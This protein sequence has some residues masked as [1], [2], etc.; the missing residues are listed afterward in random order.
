MNERARPKVAVIGAGMGG[1]CAA[2][3]LARQGDLDV[4]V[5]EAAE[6]PGGVLHTSQAEGFVREHA[7]NGF[8]PVRD[9]EG[10]LDL[11]RELGVEVA[12]AAP[13]ARKRWIYRHGKLCALPASPREFVTTDLLSF[14]G[15]LAALAEPFR[16]RGKQGDESVLAF[17]ERRLGKEVAEAIVAPFVTGVFAGNAEE[18]SIEA[19]FPAL[20]ALEE[21]GGLVVGQV[22]N[23]LGRRQEARKAGAA[24][25]KPR[26]RGGLRLAA[27]VGGV[28]ALVDALARDLG[29]ALV[30]GKTL[31]GLGPGPTLMFADGTEHKVDAVVLAT[32]AH[33][34]A[35]LLAGS[36][37]ELADALA[38]FPY[39]PVAIVYLGARRA[40]ITHPLDGFGFL[41][42]RGEDLRMLG[43]V[44]ESVLW[45]ERAPAGLVLLRCMFGGARDPG[46]MDLEDRALVEI[47][48]RDLDRAL[49]DFARVEP[50]HTHVVRWPQAIAQYTLGHGERVARAET[51]ARPLGIT[52]A[53]SAYHGVAVN[54]L[55]SDARRVVAAVLAQVGR[56]A[57][58]LLAVLLVACAG[59]RTGAGDSEASGRVQENLS[60]ATNPEQGARERDQPMT[61]TAPGEDRT[62]EVAVTVTWPH[63]PA[64]LRRPEGRNPCGAWRHAP[65]SVDT[66]GGVHQAVV[67]LRGAG[68]AAQALSRDPDARTREPGAGEAPGP[69]DAEDPGDAESAKDAEDANDAEDASDAEAAKGAEDAKDTDEAGATPAEIAVRACRLEPRVVVLAGRSP[70]LVI[71]NQDE[72]RH[73][74]TVAPASPS[75]SSQSSPPSGPPSSSVDRSGERWLP[76]IGSE[77]TLALNEPGVWKLMIA[78]DPGEPAYAIVPGPDPVALTDARG[79]VR[80]GHVPP[81]AYEVEVWH[82]PARARDAPWQARQPVA[83]LAGETTSVTISL[84]AP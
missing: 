24:E 22:K 59:G 74:I 68:D 43:T 51:L 16:R 84:N 57:A 53:G 33:V 42:A 8:L 20:K 79:A 50:V 71:R 11:C 61:R 17:A 58:V 83:V 60:P 73:R 30:T 19:G 76:L 55:V 2:R 82:A 18:L 75:P 54:R 27:P 10:A 46:V 34:S 62:G 52:L 29:D 69:E 80:F 44:F 63:A 70:E 26:Q 31:T 4:T 41:V 25:R 6:R 67:R 23:M 28:Q 36:A 32:P 35:R 38:A 81:G 7:A 66:L 49:G 5:Y 21:R 3:A 1:L 39:A 13:A 47:A 12:D 48:R 14:R 65:V 40:D 78:V 64:E 56:A 45:P 9:G 15:K 72:A 77:V 37:A